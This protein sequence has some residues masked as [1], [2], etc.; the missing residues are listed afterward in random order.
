[1]P[2][3]YVCDYCDRL[4]T[5]KHN[6]QTHIKNWHLGLSCYCDICDRNLGS[7]A[8]LILHLSHGHNSSGQPFPECDLCGR[9]FSRKQNIT[10]HMNTVHLQT[11]SA[12]SC[13][14]CNKTL[15]TGRN[16][17]RHIALMHNPDIQYL[18]CDVCKKVF[19]RKDTLIAHIQSNHLAKGSIKC[20]LCVRVYRSNKNLRRHMEMSHGQRGE[21]KCEFCPKAYTSNQSLRRH[22]RTQH[23]SEGNEQLSCG[24]CYKIIHGRENFVRHI[25]SYHNQLVPETF[26][27][28]IYDFSCELCDMNYKKEYLLRQHVK[29]A[30]TFQEFYAYCKES[31]IK[32]VEKLE[33]NKRMRE[34]GHLFRCEFCIKTLANVYELKD[35]MRAAHYKEYCLSTCNVCFQ[36][37]FSKET[38][39]RHRKTC[40]PPT[41][42]NSCAYCD[43][44]FTDIS[45]LD[46][47][48][49]I[50]HP[51]AQLVDSK[52]KSHSEDSSKRSSYKCVHCGRIYHNTRSLKHHMKLKHT[53]DD[54]VK[55]QSC[56]K[57]C[58]NKYSLAYHKMVHKNTS[59]SKCDYCEKVFKSKRNIR[60]HIEYTHLGKQRYKC[61]ECETLF[62][63]KRSLR[64]HVRIKHPNSAAFPQ[65]HICEK[66]FESA[67]SCKTHLKLIH[68]F[69]M[70]T[71]PCDLCS[72][73][74][75]SLEA[76]NI[77]LSTKHLAADEIYK[78][79]ECNFVFK[80]QEQ[81]GNHCETYHSH[82]PEAKCLPRCIICMKDFSSRKTLKRHI[83]KFHSDFNVDELATYGS[84]RLA[85][86]V[87]CG[88]C[89]RSFNDDNYFGVYLKVK[90]LRESII[91]KCETCRSSYNT[92][93]YAIQRYKQSIDVKQ[94]KLYLSELCTTQMSDDSR[95]SVEAMESD[96]PTDYIKKEPHED[97]EV[98]DE[99]TPSLNIKTEPASP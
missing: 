97:I 44:L 35:H 46:F 76:L 69:N 63:E 87:D 37:F 56:D 36:K 34:R 68:S 45:S 9:V 11:N 96:S 30:H 2:E 50:F 49:R 18:T 13:K 75:D 42:V 33:K 15:T 19:K 39:R 74:F 62:K 94:N 21:Y 99:F 29:T 48:L 72:V 71:H 79:E 32:S 1:M 16:M 6:L 89:I 27:S 90:H 4:F 73:S 85:F 41:N 70:N 84:R 88:E 54:P 77:H 52:I 28:S 57:I 93:E 60:R 51:Q 91:F 82:P 98:Y 86:N 14:I 61:I 95:D 26:E 17:K 47:H 64:K 55:C 20:D 92:L 23:L 12:I 80:G 66:R 25:T 43:K 8:G 22:L 7:P 78:C 10:S 67:K 59:W 40:I 31:L 65:C 3:Q 24:Y 53:V 5:R 38:I 81:Y 58:N 83:K